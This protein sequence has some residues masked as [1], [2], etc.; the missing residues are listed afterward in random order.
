[1][2]GVPFRAARLFTAGLFFLAQL[3]RCGSAAEPSASDG[4]TGGSVV[5][6]DRSGVE[7]LDDPGSDGWNTE[8]VAKR[9]LAAINRLASPGASPEE[10]AAVL[11]PSFSSDRLKPEKLTEVFRDVRLLVRRADAG[12]GAK[13]TD[14]AGFLAS[15]GGALPADSEVTLFKAKVI[16]LSRPDDRSFECRV[17]LELGGAS[18]SRLFGITTHWKCRWNWPSDTAEPRLASLTVE[19]FEETA[20]TGGPLFADRTVDV[21]GREPVWSAQLSRGQPEWLHLMD[22]GISRQQFGHHGLAVGDVN[23]DGLED[24]FVCQPAGLPNRL[25]LHQPDHSVREIAAAAGVDWLEPTM[26]ALLADFDNDGDAD[27]CL[28]IEQDIVFQRNDGHGIFG[29]PVIAAHGHNFMSLA[30]ADYDTDGDIDVYAT[31]YYPESHIA[32]RVAEPAPLD[33]ANNGGRNVLLRNDSTPN[34]LA[35]SDVTVSSGLDANNTRWSFG[36]AWGDIE[37]DGDPDLAV[38]NDFGRLNLFR[39]DGGRFT[40]VARD[41]GFAHSAFGM[42]AAWGDCDRDGA[43]D[44]YIGGMFTAAGARIVPQQNFLSREDGRRRETFRVMTTG[45]ALYR[46][47]GKGAFH[48]ITAASGSHM[49]RWAWAAPFA[50]VNNDGWEDMLVTN[51]WL[52]NDRED[53]L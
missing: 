50:D 32:G 14:A 23:G 13:P 20:R 35:F 11:E 8:V 40:D 3:T 19:D 6:G 17:R 45:N 48:D 1:M 53:D 9:L 41:I 46:N 12:G 2:R 52:T 51:G 36:A 44:L 16:S 5:P 26:A 22:T 18:A 29:P 28:A 49:G 37:G 27:L 7:R 33:D 25:L 24:V 10:A 30:A 38:A 4:L 39:N 42:S 31:A 21:L 43:P 47:N 15:W 34:A